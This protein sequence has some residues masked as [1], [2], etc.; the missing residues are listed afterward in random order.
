VTVPGPA[1]PDAQA[2][3]ALQQINARA[4]QTGNAADE[5][6]TTIDRITDVIGTSPQ[7]EGKDAWRARVQALR[8]AFERQLGQE[9]P[10]L[11][12]QFRR[13][14]G[15]GQPSRLPTIGGR[16]GTRGR[17]RGRR[18][19]IPRESRLP[20]RSRDLGPDGAR[21]LETQRAWEA[22]RASFL[23]VY[24]RVQDA[25]ALVDE[26]AARMAE[27]PQAQR[28]ELL[29]LWEQYTAMHADLRD[30]MAGDITQLGPG[31]RTRVRNLV[32]DAGLIAGQLEVRTQTLL[33]TG[34]R[35]VRRHVRERSGSR[36]EDIREIEAMGVSFQVALSALR[37]RRGPAGIEQM[38]TDWNRHLTVVAEY[39]G[40]LTQLEERTPGAQAQARELDQA[41]QGLFRLHEEV[42]T[43]VE[44]EA[45]GGGRPRVAPAAQGARPDR[46]VPSQPPGHG[47][48]AQP[49]RPSRRSRHCRCRTTSRH[50]L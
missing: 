5:A 38:R 1:T 4:A 9:L 48:A 13:A 12:D 17:G 11:V 43:A 8:T 36:A 27:D 15:G 22:Q 25:L 42:A 18:G 34:G 31:G 20:R 47:G 44:A 50:A 19:G 46:R 39:R 45:S 35:A 37:A 26:R 29:A 10:A 28:D 41:L 14:V 21:L 6:M 2:A 49:S 40:R 23:T 33:L 24:T 32:R 30:L 3:L 16:G 7:G